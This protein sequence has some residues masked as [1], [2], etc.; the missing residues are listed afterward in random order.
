VNRRAL[1]LCRALIFGIGLGVSRSRASTVAVIPV[2]GADAVR[3]A[4]LVEDLIRKQGMDVVQTQADA[5]QSD[6]GQKQKLTGLLSAD[7]IGDGFK[8]AES[9]KADDLLFIGVPADGHPRLEVTI[10]DAPDGLPASRSSI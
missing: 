1:F 4:P 2:D 6:A 9:V 3:L 10:Y 7:P 8:L 5:G